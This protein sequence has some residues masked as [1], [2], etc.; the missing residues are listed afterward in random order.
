MLV[1]LQDSPRALIL[2]PSSPEAGQ[3]A[4]AIST[5]GAKI[6][7]SSRNA[8]G[9]STSRPGAGG[10]T[11]LAAELVDLDELSIGSMRK[12]THTPIEGCLGII[13]IGQGEPRFRKPPCP[14]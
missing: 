7:S 10:A 4:L 11:K 13:N 3:Y 12:L 5:S 9:P 6:V 1:Y 14:I 2:L 8:A